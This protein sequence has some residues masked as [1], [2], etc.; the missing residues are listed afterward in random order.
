MSFTVDIRVESND[1]SVVDELLKVFDLG[2][3]IW[4]LWAESIDLSL[5][6][7]NSLGS[8]GSHVFSHFGEGGIHLTSVESNEVRESLHFSGS[9]SSH[10]SSVVGE[11]LDHFVSD[12]VDTSDESI[13]LVESFPDESLSLVV[14]SGSVD[15]FNS[16]PEDLEEIN[17]EFSDSGV[18]GGD[19]VVISSLQSSG[20]LKGSGLELKSSGSGGFAVSSLGGFNS[21]KHSLSLLGNESSELNELLFSEDWEVLGDESQIL[22]RIHSK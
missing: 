15:F 3:L 13:L 19:S 11:L 14:A 16:F 4:A 7:S 2:V 6:V 22:F 12:G 17:G 20:L 5:E 8:A 10:L 9:L 1:S 18:K 21:S